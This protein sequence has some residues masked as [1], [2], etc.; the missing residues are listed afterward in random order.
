MLSLEAIR[1]RL[2]HADVVKQNT[3]ANC[4]VR[5]VLGDADWV[6]W[7]SLDGLLPLLAEA[8]PSEFLKAIEHA[9]Q[10]SPCPFDELF[11]KELPG[12]VSGANYLT[13]L[14]WALEALAWDKTHL[15]P[16]C[17]T[18][19]KLADRDPGGQWLNRP[20]R[21]LNAILLPWSPQT[22]ATIEKRKV[23]LKT[24]KDEVPEVA[25]R[26]FLG[27]LPGQTRTS[28]HTHKPS[29]RNAIPEDWKG[30]VSREE[31]WEQDR[32]CARLTVEMAGNSVER[33]MQL[34]S[35]LNSLPPEAFDQA[36]EQLFSDNLSA[37]P[38]IQ[39][40]ELW[41]KANG[42]YPGTKARTSA[43]SREYSTFG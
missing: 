34:M 6:L 10:Q 25:W 39:R 35:Q 13:G 16:V 5:E 32:F 18:L 42:I 24:L 28:M 33:L 29:W 38:E 21:S 2:L 41:E 23:A 1:Q 40:T 15:V 31:R 19:G 4:V 3:R 37:I 20:A 11:S 30:D 7:S 26:L 36:M 8:S 22:T 9:L 43:V 17:V 27:L 14:L 12:P